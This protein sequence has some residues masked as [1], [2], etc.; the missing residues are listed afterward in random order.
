MCLT[1][2]RRQIVMLLLRT[3]GETGPTRT[4]LILEFDV[5]PEV[6]REQPLLIGVSSTWRAI[7]LHPSWGFAV[8][9][10]GVRVSDLIISSK[11][12]G[13]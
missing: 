1:P 11:M 6:R 9:D 13:R 3:L 4:L 5:A 2:A 7:G 10:V 8:S 12:L